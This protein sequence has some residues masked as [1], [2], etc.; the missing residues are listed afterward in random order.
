M[1]AIIT[2]NVNGEMYEMAVNPWQT[3]LEVLRDELGLIG[4][5]KA[6]SI[7]TCGACT[8]IVDSKAVLSC[9]TLAIECEGHSVTTIEGIEGPEGLHPIQQSFIDNGAVQCGFCTPGVI[10]TAKALLDEN[11]DPSDDEIRDALSGNFCRCT[12]HIK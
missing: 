10:M 4:T 1:K 12:G 8:V 5:K 7:G 3:L 6:C 2:L 9:L 11:P